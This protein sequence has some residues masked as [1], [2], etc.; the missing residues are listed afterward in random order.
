LHN[1]LALSVLYTKPFNLCIHARFVG[2]GVPPDS[3]YLVDESK[4]E[5]FNGYSIEV[6]TVFV[7]DDLFLLLINQDSL[8]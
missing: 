3:C 1:L 2:K 7:F 4:L 8:P 6:Y 5:L